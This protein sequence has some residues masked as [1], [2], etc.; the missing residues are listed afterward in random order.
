[1]T[2]RHKT[3]TITL[4]GIAAI[5]LSGFAQFWTMHRI[6]AAWDQYANEAATREARLNEI[7]EQFGY[8]G[9]IHNFKNF[10]LRGDKKFLEK[11]YAN[12]ET[13]EKSIAGYKALNLSEEEKKAVSIVE[14]VMQTYVAESATVDALWDIGAPAQQIDGRVK[15][16]DG[17]AFK[18]FDLLNENFHR[19]SEDADADMAQ[20]T[21]LQIIFLIASFVLLSGVIIGSVILLRTQTSAID[22]MSH[23]MVELEA[24]SDFSKRMHDGRN[25][26]LGM[27][28]ATFDKLLAN[29]E[30][31]LTLNRA[32]LDAVPDPIFLSKDGKI[33]SGNTVAATYAGVH[34][35]DFKGMDASNV[36]V[37]AQNAADHGDYITCLKA[38]EEVILDE[39][40][41]TVKDRDGSILG[42]LVVARDVTE[43]IR[44]EAE[45]AANLN[46]IREVGMEISSAAQ[47]L[48]N[49]TEALS[50]RIESISEGAHTQQ[51]ISSEAAA[52][53]GQMNET[54]SEVARNASGA[55]EQAEEARTRAAEGSK[56]VEESIEAI[57]SVSQ[58]AGDLKL[59]MDELG[60]HTE[61]IG[62]IIR[63][64]NDIADQTNL[65]ALN[66]AIEAA[67]A[68]EAGRGFAVV[69]D[70]VRKLAE[71][72]MDATKNVAEA[73]ES[74][75]QVARHNIESMDAAALSV[76]QATEFAGKS[77]DAL[78][79]IVQL[80]EG[81]TGQVR[82]IA[83]AAEE[84]SAA[85]E[86]VMSSVSEVSVISDQTADGMREST[87]A[88]RTLADLAQRLEDL[89]RK[90]G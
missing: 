5:L 18:A 4:V 23:A 79:A 39:V 13:M 48:V 88:I 66:A 24:N 27:L 68:G 64:I 81:T 51:E 47:E 9:I 7:K 83:T 56:I 78:Q 90:A 72:T 57:S 40:S 49:S 16:N 1:M 41:T 58:Q 21:Q 32:V 87:N 45:A 59:S 14:S 67:R 20:A 2:L 46:M 8:G 19:I 73:I 11:L 82:S 15:I 77:G 70:E 85:S 80:V 12:K 71:K 61:S 62:D 53:M 30:S 69:A 76:T 36:L 89:A 10:V 55:A 29:I 33:V 54:V 3:L 31:M 34:I 44:R 35:K 86:H 17:P 38:G 43:I 60:S 22:S 25:D 74:I 6:D 52:A 75:Q 84:Q 26:E 50:T 42:D 63:V 37:R 28:T 65:L